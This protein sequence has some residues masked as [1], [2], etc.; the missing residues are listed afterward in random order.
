MKFQDAVGMLVLSAFVLSF[1][2]FFPSPASAGGI[3]DAVR[4]ELEAASRLNERCAGGVRMRPGASAAQRERAA[5]ELE[6]V[7]EGA[8]DAVAGLRE[9]GWCL[10]TGSDERATDRVWRKCSKSGD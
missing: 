3:P 10:G 7:C 2:A 1:S 9:R 5:A 8:G 6:A 4:R